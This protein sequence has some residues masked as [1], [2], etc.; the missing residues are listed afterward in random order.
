MESSPVQIELREHDRRISGLHRT[1]GGLSVDV[2]QHKTDI[3]VLKRD[4]HEVADDIADIKK[5]VEEEGKRNRAS[6]NKVIWALVTLALST[7]GSAIAVSLTL[8]GHP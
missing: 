1:V 7:A 6:N 8:G 4:V 3:E 5:A 2:A